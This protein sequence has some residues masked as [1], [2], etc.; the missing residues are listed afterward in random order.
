MG[1]VVGE[2]VAPIVGDISPFSQSI[3]QASSLGGRF[4]SEFGNVVKGV[5]DSVKSL[6]AK[7]TKYISLP[8]TGAATAVFSFGKDFEKELS[9]VTGLVGV[10]ASQV[11]EWGNDILD[12]A[13]KIARAP[14]ELASALFFVT[15]AG[16]KGAEA[17]EVLEMSGK[18]AAAGLGETETIADLVTSAMNAYG[19]ENLSAAEATDTLVAAVR[20]G[21]AEAAALAG[22]MGQVLPLAAEMG[23]T[24]DQ[25]AA[26]QAA[27]TRTGTTADEAATQLKSIMAGLIKPAK[28]AE[29]QLEKMGTSSAKLR[30]Q[31]KEEGLLTA[32]SDLRTMTKKYGEEAMARVFPNIRA[33]MGVL[34]LMGSNAEANAEIF[35]KVSDAT[36]SLDNAFQAASETLDFKW[37]AALAQ[38]KSTAIGFFDILKAN[39]VP[40]LETLISVLKWVSTSF[41]SLSP[42]VQNL[43]VTLSGLGIIVGPI[44]VGLGGIIAAVGAGIAGLGGI[45]TTLGG[46]IAT[47][48]LPALGA[49]IGIGAAIIAAIIPVIAVIGALIA[50]FVNLYKNNEAFK[51]K[52]LTTWE[53][54]K[55][56]ASN[57]FNNI[58]SVILNVLSKVEEFWAKHGDQIM[59]YAQK[60]W[61][62][63]LDYILVII[64]NLASAIQ[65]GTSIIEGDWKVAWDNIKLIFIRAWDLISGRINTILDTIATKISTKFDE[66]KTTIKVKLDEI[67]ESIK[68]K[69]DEIATNI[70]T[71]LETTLG[72]ITAWFSSLPSRISEFLERLK[73]TL[74]KWMEAQNEEN[75]RQFGIWWEA[76]KNWFA[77]IP[78]KIENELNFWANAIIK[79]FNMIKEN[80]AIKL[81]EWWEKINK[82][83]KN[84]PGRIESLLKNWKETL[85][86]WFNNMKIS[87]QDHLN[88]WWET[89]K[90]WFVRAPNKPEVK[91]AGKNIVKKFSQGSGEEKNRFMSKLGKI[92]VDA[93]KYIV[94]F[95]GVTLIATGREIIERILKGVNQLKSG[96]YNAGQKII[97]KIIAGLK[98]K[99]RAV[100]KTAANIAQAIKDFFPFSPAKEGPLKDLNKLDFATSITKSLKDA[101]NAIKK[102]F[103]GDLLIGGIDERLLTINK[104]TA[105]IISGPFNFYGVQDTQQFMKEMKKLTLRVGGKRYG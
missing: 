34:D 83:F 44:L 64:E 39:L 103:L 82:W 27:M 56:N 93:A 28:Q 2:V 62:F 25:V 3:G 22:S 95:A 23:V 4:V 11:D 58:K 96:F 63:I 33:L 94:I 14:Q 100:K 105:P 60:I 61:N 10:A 80:I 72:I 84:I 98:S 9:K 52:V 26:A 65:I 88:R 5:G 79:G 20:E 57:I 90:S 91:N 78:A 86:R 47:I 19:V 71:K 31:I 89:I 70:Q 55:V 42:S 49:L 35:D 75:K 6:G 74:N 7:I 102:N 67:I 59:N 32:L 50:S 45:V 66:I 13:P 8:L 12:L 99:L 18:A 37:N 73:E 77:S 41:K 104:S 17:M 24:F 21:K 76:I 36:G 1:F 69:F 54:I 51:K 92:V 46:V 68:I 101:E 97:D 38:V 53:L 85:S 30:K 29:G 48:G 87:I 40:K 43:I 15:S 81:K 16:I